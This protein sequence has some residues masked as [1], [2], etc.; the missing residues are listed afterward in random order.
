MEKLKVLHIVEALGG[1]VYSYFIDLTNYFG[2]D[3]ETVTTIIYSDKR[4]EIMPGKIKKDFNKNVQLINVPMSKE[5]SIFK[6]IS[7]LINLIKHIKRLR[8]NIIHLH[9]SKMSVV[10]RLAY[11]FSFSKSKLFYTPHGYAF[12]RQ[13]V[14][15]IKKLL[16]YFIE[17]TVPFFGGETIAC[18]DTEFNYAKKF[19]KASLIRNGINIENVIKLMSNTPKKKLTFGTLGRITHAR[20]PKLFNEIALQNPKINFLWIGDGELKHLI[21]AKNVKITGWFMNR[22][23]G[24]KK[25]NNI[26]VY[27]QTSLWEGLPIALLEAMAM[28]KPIIATNIIGNKDIVKHAETGYLFSSLSE[29][30]GFLKFLKNKDKREALGNKGFK[31]L[32]LMFNST[33]NFNAMK[34]IYK[35]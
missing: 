5:I 23:E 17:K 34:N 10:G 9:S 19:G 15:Y 32:R 21:T 2:K 29:F 16:Y 35:T 8:P 26:D 20:N 27:L 22:D 11:V 30:N 14:S 7:S 18:G 25:L 24:I 31:R 33:R 28:K 3:Q 4:P 1:G 12:L 6:D 13:D